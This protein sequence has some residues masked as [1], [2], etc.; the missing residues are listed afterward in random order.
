MRNEIL[1]SDEIKIKLVETN[2][3]WCVEPDCTSG[4]F[5]AY[6]EKSLL[7]CSAPRFK[8]LK[9]IFWLILLVRVCFYAF[10]SELS[11]HLSKVLSISVSECL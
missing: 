6:S 11:M 3:K 7:E 10:V 4:N 5:H 8:W 1:W 2:G 9:F